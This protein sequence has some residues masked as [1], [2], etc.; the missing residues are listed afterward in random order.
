MHCNCSGAKAVHGCALQGPAGVGG[1]AETAETR[2]SEAMI[3][4]PLTM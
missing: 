1:L 2:G 4:A 3:A